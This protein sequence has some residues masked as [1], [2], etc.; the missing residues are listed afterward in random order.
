MLAQVKRVDDVRI[1][2]SVVQITES[3][4]KCE[5]ILVVLIQPNLKWTQHCAE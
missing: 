3:E 5:T 4:G 2:M 1:S